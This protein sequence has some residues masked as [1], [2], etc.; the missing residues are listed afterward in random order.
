MI[1]S[2]VIQ[3]TFSSGRPRVLFEG[4]FQ[5]VSAVNDYDLTPDGREFLMLR[6]ASPR[7]GLTECK[8]V[9]NYLQEL[10]KLE[11]ARTSP[12]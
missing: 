8:V 12:H 10:K 5:L 9:L 7:R 2:V 1:A 4:S 3:P 11:A 6:D